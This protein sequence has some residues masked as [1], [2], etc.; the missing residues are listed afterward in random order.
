MA[1]QSSSRMFCHYMKILV[2]SLG[3]ISNHQDVHFQM[4]GSPCS[5]NPRELSSMWPG[6]GLLH[7]T[8]IQ[9]HPP[10]QF[11]DP[12]CLQVGL[13]PAPLGTKWRWLRTGRN[14]LMTLVTLDYLRRSWDIYTKQRSNFKTK[15]RKNPL[16]G[17]LK[18]QACFRTF[19]EQWLF[20]LSSISFLYSL[21]LF[22]TVLVMCGCLNTF[23]FICVLCVGLFAT[24]WTLACQ[25]S[26]CPGNNAKV[27]CI[28]S[29]RIFLTQG[30]NYSLLHFLHWLMDS[31]PLSL[32]QFKSVWIQWRKKFSSWGSLATCQVSIVMCLL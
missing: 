21:I 18:S 30:L 3:D 32:L 25:D 5:P 29:T 15:E 12:Y 2:S 6:A 8:S 10:V 4:G 17:R 20:F 26:L 28:S 13:T 27:G 9:A 24:P 16:L 7:N 11:S 1:Q 31:L 14:I 19:A 22:Q 23:P